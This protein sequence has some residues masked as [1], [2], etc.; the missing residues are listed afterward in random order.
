MKHWQKVAGLA[1]LAF[2]TDQTALAKTVK[3]KPE[4]IAAI[5]TVRISDTVTM[6]GDMFYQGRAETFAMSAAIAEG[7]GRPPEAKPRE[8]KAQVIETMKSG[9]VD[10]RSITREQ[11]AKELQ[12]AGRMNVVQDGDADATVSLNLEMYGL[13]QRSGFSP[14]L[15]P[16][17]RVEATMTRKDGTVVWQNSDYI[18]P[19]NKENNLGHKEEEYAA[20]PELLRETWVNIAGI[21]SRVVLKTLYPSTK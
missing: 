14:I 6:A 7:D 9:Q 10:L 18:T 4:V 12:K 13:G 5:K 21:V 2:A 20:Q 3:A 1:L 11:F 19:Q 16:V 15:Y 8:P 17:L